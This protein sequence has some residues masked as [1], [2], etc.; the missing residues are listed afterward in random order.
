MG[1]RLRQL[2]GSGPEAVPQQSSRRLPGVA[3]VIVN[4]STGER[5]EAVSTDDG[6]VRFVNLVPGLY[7]LEAELTGFQRWMREGLEVNVQT[8]PRV[9]VTLALVEG[10]RTAS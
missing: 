6:S 10:A 3:V 1:E 9:E 4:M 5:R 8:T 7:R 2:R